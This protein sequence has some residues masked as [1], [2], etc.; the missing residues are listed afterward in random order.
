MDT[1]T[2]TSSAAREGP[3]PAGAAPARAAAGKY[4]IFQ[5]ADEAYGLAIVKVREIVRLANVTRMPRARDYVRG[6]AQLRGTVVPVVDLRVKLGMARAEDTD[7]TV[8][9]VVQHE[10]AG[11]ELTLGILVDRVLEVLQVD[12]A[13]IEPPPALDATWMDTSFLLGVAKS[14]RRV[15]FLLDGERVLSSDE[16]TE[17]ELAART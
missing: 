13:S 16:A 5:L 9:I 4:M 15:I 10:V 8:V 17:L 2:I 3:Q 1:P 7:Q 12:A 11:R 14:E 6:V